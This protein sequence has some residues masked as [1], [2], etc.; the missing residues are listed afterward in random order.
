MKTIS[1]K[2]K[3]MMVLTFSLT[4]GAAVQVGLVRDSY[5]RNVTMVAESALSSAQRTFDS[6]KARQLSSLALASSALAN[7]EAIRDLIEKG[8]REALHTYLAPLYNDL[9]SREVPIM[10]FMDKDGNALLRMQNPKSFGD[11]LQAITT[12]RKT[13]QTKEVAAGVDLAKPGL[14]AGSSRP[15]FGKDGTVVGYIVVGGSLDQF[16][17][18]MKAQTADDYI[19]MGYK[20][21][22][23]EKLYR[24]GRKARGQPDT[25][26]QFGTILV[27]GKTIEPQ[28]TDPYEKELQHLPAT[29]RLLERTSV[30]GKTLVRGV[31]PLYD[32]AGGAIGGIFVQHDI[33]ALH[34]GM[35]RVQ[36]LAIAAV[37]ALTLLL[38]F[39]IAIVLNRLVFARLRRT[40]DIVT[41]VVGGEFSQKIVPVSSDEVGH[42]EELFEQFRTIFVGLVDDVSKQQAQEDE[43]SA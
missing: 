14:S 27:F 19:L 13:M 7:V 41:R 2:T 31:F 35:K 30:D 21:F 38:C 5:E 1:I 33:T 43:R 39:T 29:G 24:N 34:Q 10:T 40:M 4:V 22:L 17:V 26:D 23:D 37:I 16:V 20:S 9:K 6:L 15:V 28:A 32:A 36:N 3:V 18:T 11:S 8:D 12:V 25:W 42:L